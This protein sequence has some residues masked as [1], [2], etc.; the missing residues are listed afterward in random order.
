MRFKHNKKRNT[1]FLYE[2]LLKEMSK[3]V[4]KGDDRKRV[5]IMTILKDFFSPGKILK[6]ELALYK[7]LYET[8]KVDF[9]TAERVI[10]EARKDYDNLDT[11]LVFNE[12]T[13]LINM[14]NKKLGTEVFS[15]FVPN[16]RSLATISQIFNTKMPA[17][18]RVLLERKILS[19]MVEKEQA[20]TKMT[21]MPALD[22]LTYNTFVDKFN[23]KYGSE[24]LKEQ[25]DLLTRYILSLT[26][27]GVSLKIFLNE[28][29]SRLKHELGNAVETEKFKN[30]GMIVEKISDVAN[31]LES[32][33]KRKLDGMVIEKILRVQSFVEEM[34]RNGDQD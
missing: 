13:R 10:Q 1:A 23:D 14:I 19:V 20:P 28:E 5:V 24:L 9:Y 27:N 18:S 31:L 22:K 17:K 8:K 21:N 33:S 34:N 12:Q 15:A 16:Y 3:A 29:I 7:F 2:S 11:K 30:D 25:K 26:D 32:F 6:E 4:V